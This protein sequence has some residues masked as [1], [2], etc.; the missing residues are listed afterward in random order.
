MYYVVF[1][2]SSFLKSNRSVVLY[3]AMHTDI[4]SFARVYRAFGIPLLPE[5]E[6]LI[7]SKDSHIWL[8]MIEP[9]SDLSSL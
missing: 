5:S 8:H 1:Y 3:N 9:T 4:K 2:F 6:T 7:S